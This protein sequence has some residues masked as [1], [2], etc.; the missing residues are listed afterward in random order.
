MS[1][2]PLPERSRNLTS[3]LG[4]ELVSVYEKATSTVIEKVYRL[5]F[6]MIEASS[7]EG[8][9]TMCLSR[10]HLLQ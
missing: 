10:I 8:L 5:N 6:N 7:I 9:K 1:S 4:L 2:L 3:M